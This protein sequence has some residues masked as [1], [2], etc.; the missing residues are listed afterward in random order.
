[1]LAG[2]RLVEAVAILTCRDTYHAA[3]AR[4]D[5]LGVVS[6]SAAKPLSWFIRRR[7]PICAPHRHSS[8]LPIV[9]SIFSTISG[10]LQIPQSENEP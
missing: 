7:F 4:D 3:T 2:S 5:E 8:F 1:M 10:F 9:S 6:H